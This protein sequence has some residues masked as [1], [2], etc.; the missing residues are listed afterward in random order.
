MA[1]TENSVQIT[2]E[3]QE[4]EDTGMTGAK[5]EGLEKSDIRITD[6]KME[7]WLYLEDPGEG[8]YYT[9]EELME[10]LKAHNVT[11][12]INTS[13][14]AAMA[15]KGIY[16]REIKIATGK[17]ATESVDGW[18]EYFV[19]PKELKAA[20]K[21]REDGSVDY[22]SM[23]EL[24]SIEVGD[25]IAKYHKP[26]QGEDG[27]YVDGVII[28]AAT[29][30]NLPPLI[31][32]GVKP[33]PENDAVYIA[34]Q[35]GKIEIK[36]NKVD[37]KPVHEIMEDVDYLMGKV[38]FPGDIVISGSVRS[39]VII[40]SGRNVTV[41]GSVEAAEIYAEGDIILKRGI[42]GAQKAKICAQNNVYA[43]FIEHADVTAGVNVESNIILNSSIRAGNKVVTTGKQGRILGGHVHGLCGIEIQEAGNDIGRKTILHAG[44]ETETYN[45]YQ[46]ATQRAK[47]LSDKITNIV[48]EM[49]EL[50]IFKKRRQKDFDLEKD[51]QYKMMNKEKEKMFKE[52]EDAK[53]KMEEAKEL[54]DKA[55]DA[56]IVVDGSIYCGV[57]IGINTLVLPI[58]KDNCF[59]RYKDQRGIIVSEVIVH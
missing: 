50:I 29:P 40:R 51:V 44:Y 20:P 8:I 42:Q 27:Y 26:I 2:Q 15:R 13:H 49:K 55:K 59:M 25:F 58:Q 4:T 38:E 28:R 12:G 47:L 17:E 37:I 24:Q 32:A 43:D 19:S 33:H 6:D 3:T 56:E 10:Y 41:E 22:T 48:E 36:D 46:D 5:L 39:N 14:I 16:D 23:S 18:Y 7:A 11:A 52:L 31:G 30:R 9:K 1:E 35:S 21:V 45:A 54:M 34:I 57:H 53:A